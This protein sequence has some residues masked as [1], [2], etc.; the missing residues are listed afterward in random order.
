MAERSLSPAYEIDDCKS[1][2]I[3][4]NVSKM[5]PRISTNYFLTLT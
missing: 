3:S 5:L 2:V 1:S 4:S